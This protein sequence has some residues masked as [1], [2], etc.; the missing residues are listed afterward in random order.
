MRVSDALRAGWLYTV[1]RWPSTLLVAAL[2]IA[3]ALAGLVLILAVLGGSLG[4]RVMLAGV[5]GA[6]VLGV[7]ARLGQLAALAGAVRTGAAWVN[8]RPEEHL[9][10]AVW[11][12]LPRAA[13]FFVFSL[14]ID[15]AFFLWKWLGLF[16]VLLGLG[17][18]VTQWSGVIGEAGALALFLTLSVFLLALD[19][20]WRKAALVR[21]V[22]H[23][24][25]VARSLF[26][27]VTLV[28][29]RPFARAAVVFTPL[30][31]A[32]GLVLFFNIFAGALGQAAGAPSLPLQLSVEL[33]SSVPSAFALAFAELVALQAL[34]AMDL[35]RATAV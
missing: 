11:K 28:G 26:E 21:A 17:P 30:V 3:E 18:A 10:D 20:V 31:L 29:E 5:G 35:P 33:A 34:A 23:D 9:V 12:A 16:A 6:L 32:A 2:G 14:P 4:P 24:R 22:V 19:V 1:S 13:S 8:A 15:A 27:A 25:G 7:L